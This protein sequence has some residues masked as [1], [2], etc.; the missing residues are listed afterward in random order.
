MELPSPSETFDLVMSDGAVIRARRHGNPDGLRLYVSHGNGFA[1][2]AYYPFWRLLLDRFDLILFD[3]RN[4]GQNPPAGFDGHN[5]MQMARDI[6]DV[7]S[8]MED[9]LG[10]GPKVG[11]FHSMSAR[12]RHETRG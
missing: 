2:D 6:G 10:A 5:Y 7:V 12:G 11:V 8:I 9:R 4:H 1:V 3:M